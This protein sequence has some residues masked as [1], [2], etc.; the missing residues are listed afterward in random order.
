MTEKY[1][2]I[3]LYLGKTNMDDVLKN[4]KVT[5][6]ATALNTD[7]SKSSSQVIV[8]KKKIALRD[9]NKKTIQKLEVGTELLIIGY[10]RNL[11][12]FAAIVVDGSSN[13]EEKAAKGAFDGYV[14]GDYL[15]VSRAEL[16]RQFKD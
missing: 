10:D 8:E 11:D 7:F 5:K 12:M 16:L 4:G 15:S 3:V 1:E 13:A 9:E 14:H 6:K 2:N